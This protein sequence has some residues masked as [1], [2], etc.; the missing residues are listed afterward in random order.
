[1]GSRPSKGDSRP[2]SISS[3]FAAPTDRP[4]KMLKRSICHLPQCDG[5]IYLVHMD[6]AADEGCR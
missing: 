6:H 2:E 1:M 3:F 4:P 5:P